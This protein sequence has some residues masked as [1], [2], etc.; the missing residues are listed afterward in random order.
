ML[1]KAGF[2]IDERRFTQNRY[3]YI[4]GE[5]EISEL[6]TMT[7]A[8]ASS[9]FISEEKSDALIKKITA[10][11]SINKTRALKRNM[12]VDGRDKL[13]NEQIFYIIDTTSE[14]IN[15]RKKIRFRKIECN[16]E[17]RVLHLGGE[18]YTFSPY[19]LVWDGD[20][21]YGGGLFGQAREHRQPPGEPHC[22]AVGN[23]SGGCGA[24]EG[25]F[26][27]RKVCENHL[28]DVQRPSKRGGAALRQRRDECGRRPVRAGRAHLH[29]EP[30]EFPV[31]EEV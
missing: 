7:D 17:K 8:I 2:G 6:K 10:L 24:A 20:N 22:G 26:L 18:K 28:P 15:Q 29:R 30:A 31:I 4:E 25:R 14:A 21:Y 19:S 9:I 12:V 13:E 1:Q 27:R 5:F 11:A 23:P 3:R 16:V